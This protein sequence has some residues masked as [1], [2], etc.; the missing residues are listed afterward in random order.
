L[1]DG[2]ESAVEF[3]FRHS[4]GKNP[5][6]DTLKI[7]KAG[8][9]LYDMDKPVTANKLLL[10]R[11]MYTNGELDTNFMNDRNFLKALSIN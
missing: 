7:S 2:L 3:Y 8:Q 6:L 4:Y 9:I 5:K 10:F 11:D 1:D